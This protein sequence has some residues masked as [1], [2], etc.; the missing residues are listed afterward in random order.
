[1]IIEERRECQHKKN[2]WCNVR[3]RDGKSG[4]EKASMMR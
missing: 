1:M 3:K 4:K 2:K